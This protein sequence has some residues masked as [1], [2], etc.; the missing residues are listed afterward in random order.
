M[1]G[2]VTQSIGQWQAWTPTFTGFSADPSSVTA[3]YTLNGKMCT[4]Y[5]DSTAGTSNAT[6]FT[7]TLP[8]A[9][10]NTSSQSFA[11]LMVSNNSA[12]TTSPG[13]IRTRVN[14]NVADLYLNSSAAAWTASGTK[15]ARISS[16]AYEIV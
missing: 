8:F 6:T 2:T 13:L 7:I 11:G 1:Y 9:A 15:N 4:I 12:A 14:S 3:R 16:F 10:A 5:L